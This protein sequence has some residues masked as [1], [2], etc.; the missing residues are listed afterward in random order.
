MRK[1]TAAAL[2][3]ASVAAHPAAAQTSDPAGE[4]CRLAGAIAQGTDATVAQLL[5]MAAVWP[6]EDRAKLEPI[7]RP[8]LSRFDMAP[9]D[10][11][12]IAEFGRYAREYL[13]AS[14]DRKGAGNVYFRILYEAAPNGLYF[15]NAKFNSDY[16][17]IIDPP[18]P[19]TPEKIICR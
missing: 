3:A 19:Q 17:V 10:V 18:F 5:Q 13:I 12:E 15:K 16:Y 7:F 9:G 11:F 6:D 1:T 4:V 2:L 8:Q 14:A